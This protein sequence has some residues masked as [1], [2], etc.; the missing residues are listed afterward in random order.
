MAGGGRKGGGGRGG[1]GELNHGG[2]GTEDQGLQVGLTW[3]DLAFGGADWCP[4]S[5]FRCAV[6]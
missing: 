1:P 3:V 2:R 4:G 6:C 5:V